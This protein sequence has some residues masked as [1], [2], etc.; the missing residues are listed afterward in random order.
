MGKTYR[1]I[2]D[3]KRDLRALEYDY[4]FLKIKTVDYNE[5]KPNLEK[6]L[7]EAAEAINK[8]EAEKVVGYKPTARTSYDSKKN[9]PHAESKNPEPISGEGTY[10]AI[11]GSSIRL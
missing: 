4:N 1:D 7:K 6:E 5:I 10:K 11:S 3:I 8:G 9:D 2:R